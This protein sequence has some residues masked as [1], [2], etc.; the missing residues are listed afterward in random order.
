MS[1]WIIAKGIPKRKTAAPIT[2]YHTTELSAD[3]PSIY[4]DALAAFI[5]SQKMG[6]T[7]SIWDPS[8]ILSLSLQYNPQMKLLKEKPETSAS[9][10]SSYSPSLAPMKLKDIQKI[11]VTALQYNSN[12]NQSVKQV[13]EKAGIRQV[14]DIAIHLVGPPGENIQIYSDILKAY[15]AKSKK[16]IL[17]IYVMADSY[18]SVLALQQSGPPSWKIVSLS[19]TPVKV[20]SEVFIQTMAE[21][22]LL[23]STPALVLDFS[24]SLDRLVYVLQRSPTGLDFFKEIKDRQWTLI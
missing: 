22:Q 1:S 9:S 23:S 24:Q 3:I 7:C 21:V 8:T 14:F 2:Q 4:T 12:F 11:A 5:H 15:Q 19:R 16:T 18:A 13:L 20:P 6:E 17:S 10:V